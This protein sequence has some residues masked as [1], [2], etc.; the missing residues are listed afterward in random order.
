M[1]PTLL[2]L[3]TMLSFGALA[4]NLTVLFLSLSILKA[5]TYSVHDPSKEILYIP[6][7]NAVKFRA[8]FWIDV[9]GERISKAIGSGFNTF[10]GSVDRSI[11]IGSIPSLLSAAGLWVVCYYVGIEFD[12]LLATGKIVGLEQSVDPATYKRV[13]DREAKRPSEV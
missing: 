12:R 13:A 10:A 5:M 7:S 3:V 4:G 6:T 2:L 11:Q 9:V 1:F 8:K